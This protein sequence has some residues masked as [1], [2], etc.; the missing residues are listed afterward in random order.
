M[1]GPPGNWIAPPGS[2]RSGG[3]GNKAVGAS[4]VEGRIRRLGESVGCNASVRLDLIP[5]KPVSIRKKSVNK[6]DYALR[7]REGEYNNVLS[8]E[9]PMRKAI[10]YILGI[11]GCAIVALVV[12]LVLSGLS[13]SG[14]V[15]M[16]I[17][18]ALFLWVPEILSR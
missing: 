18:H 7:A 3:G 4:G 16:Q 17:T 6:R 8:V 10:E 14:V 12:G 15:S 2:N 11:L 13:A 9:V 5:I 1:K